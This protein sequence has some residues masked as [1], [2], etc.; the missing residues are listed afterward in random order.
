[1]RLLA[2]LD[3]L[4]ENAPESAPMIA[5]LTEEA[6]YLQTQA[7]G[8]REQEAFLARKSLME[9]VQMSSTGRSNVERRQRNRSKR[10]F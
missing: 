9:D 3:D 2:G 7:R 1:M 4:P 8:A 6:E 5:R 10:Q